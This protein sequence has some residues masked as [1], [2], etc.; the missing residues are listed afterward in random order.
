MAHQQPIK[1]N[2]CKKLHLNWM[3]N[4]NFQILEIGTFPP[5]GK[6]YLRK[7]KR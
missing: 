2:T 5:V 7:G 3:K 1:I 4:K 6:L